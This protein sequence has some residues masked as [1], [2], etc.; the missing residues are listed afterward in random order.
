MSH[1]TAPLKD[2]FCA[3]FRP[4]GAE[5]YQPRA[6]PWGNGDTFLTQPKKALKGR[7][8]GG[9]KAD[10]SPFQAWGLLHFLPRAT[11]CP[12]EAGFA[13]PWADMFLPLRGVKVSWSMCLQT[14]RIAKRR[15]TV[16]ARRSSRFHAWTMRNSRTRD[17]DDDEDDSEDTKD[18]ALT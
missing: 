3:F 7:N 11:L 17:E 15:C 12:P 18:R 4:E 10:T 13:L 14:R 8:N 9:W 16:R 5:T 2:E 1:Y 6:T